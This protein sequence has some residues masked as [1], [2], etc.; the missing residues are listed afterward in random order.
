MNYRD[1]LNIIADILTAAS[2]NAKRTQIMYQ[3]NLSY[4][5]LMRYLDEVVGA[6]LLS[7]ENEQQQYVLTEKGKQFLI[8]YKEYF[9]SSKGVEKRLDEMR[10]KKK[11]LEDFCKTSN[12]ANNLATG[13]K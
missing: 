6:S 9:R 1:K 3:A 13:A 10:L 4:K 8:T 7:F 12:H 2:P 11:N 5:V